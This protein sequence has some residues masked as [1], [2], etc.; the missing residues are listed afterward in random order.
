MTKKK[1]IEWLCPGSIVVEHLTHIPKVDGSN[2]ATCTGKDKMS[3]K[4]LLYG[5]AL[6]EQW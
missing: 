4:T 5:C 2:P 3:R 6:V 1:I